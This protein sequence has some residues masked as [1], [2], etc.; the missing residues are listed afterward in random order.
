MLPSCKW[1]KRLIFQTDAARHQGGSLD[2]WAWAEFQPP[3]T[4]LPGLLCR[5]QIIWLFSAALHGVPPGNTALTHCTRARLTSHL[6]LVHCSSSEPQP[7]SGAGEWCFV[8]L[9]DIL[10]QLWNLFIKAKYLTKLKGL[11]LPRCGQGTPSGQ[12]VDFLQDN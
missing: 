8:F 11:P 2:S 5:T 1:E 9:W 6:T 7:H 10:L 4:P 12:R 3:L